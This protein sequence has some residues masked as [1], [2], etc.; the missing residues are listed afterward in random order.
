MSSSSPSRARRAHLCCRRRLSR[1]PLPP[2]AATVTVCAA[3]RAEPL[4][5][6]PSGPA[7]LA[8]PGRAGCAADGPRAPPRGER[9]APRRS[10]LCAAAEAPPLR[11]SP[12]GESW[13]DPRAAAMAWSGA[14]GDRGREREG[15]QGVRIWLSSSNQAH[16]NFY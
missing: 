12:A 11:S 14:G 6:P 16:M 3:C 4:P 15:V 1:L 5:P 13:P 9:A 2:A 8:T 10:S 7:N